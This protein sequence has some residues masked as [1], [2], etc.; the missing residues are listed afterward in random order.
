MIDETMLTKLRKSAKTFFQYGKEEGK[1][2][3]IEETISE[4]SEEDRNELSAIFDNVWET[5]RI[6]YG[7]F[8]ERM[9]GYNRE[10]N[11]NS[12]YDENA[13]DG[14]IV[15]SNDSFKMPYSL[16][17]RSYAVSSTNKAFLPNMNG[18]SI[19][20]TS[21]DETDPNVRLE[22]YIKEEHGGDKGWS[23]DYCYIL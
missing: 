21:L 19:Y 13:L 9:R 4:C 12:L 17:A 22:N 10:N 23:V 15:F 3:F 14:V 16:P 20:G 6:T 1:E 18:Y 8:K 11:I 7:E 5:E 2:R